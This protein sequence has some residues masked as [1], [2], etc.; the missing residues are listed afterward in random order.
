MRRNTEFKIMLDAL[1]SSRVFSI[2]HLLT[3]RYVSEC[4]GFVHDT[5]LLNKLLLFL[6]VKL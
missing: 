3:V 1:E 5:E 2:C 4:P 6:S